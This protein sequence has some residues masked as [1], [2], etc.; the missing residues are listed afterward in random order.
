[1]SGGYDSEPDNTR[2]PTLGRKHSFLRSKEKPWEN[3]PLQENVRHTT[4][5]RGL[6]PSH[7]A[8]DIQAKAGGAKKHN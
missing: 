8:R 4:P 6:P 1:M 7:T 5:P 3:V 2:G